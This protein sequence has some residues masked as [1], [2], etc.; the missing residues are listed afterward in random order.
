M[1]TSKRNQISRLPLSKTNGQCGV[2]SRGLVKANSPIESLS[3]FVRTILELVRA[4]RHQLPFALAAGDLDEAVKT[5]MAKTHAAVFELVS[6][7]ITALG[8]T[9]HDGTAELAAGALMA[10]GQAPRLALHRRD[11]VERTVAFVVAGVRAT[12]KSRSKV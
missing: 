7:A 12:A 11:L 1:N 5:S 6:T 4:G 2:I 10:A 3:T 9:D 8:A